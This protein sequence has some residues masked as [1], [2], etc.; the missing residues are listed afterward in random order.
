MGDF[1]CVVLLADYVLIKLHGVVVY[2]YETIFNT[3]FI[4]NSKIAALC[5]WNH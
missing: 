4:I 2:E 1:V 3:N 5:N